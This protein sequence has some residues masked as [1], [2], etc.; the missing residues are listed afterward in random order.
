MISILKFSTLTV[1]SWCSHRDG[2]FGLGRTIR[3]SI[4]PKYDLQ[5]LTIINPKI[6]FYNILNSISLKYNIPIF[7]S[8]DPRYN[9]TVSNSLNPKSVLQI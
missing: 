7:N 2:D 5:Y 4:D 8:T 1:T 3:Y 9:L 6:R